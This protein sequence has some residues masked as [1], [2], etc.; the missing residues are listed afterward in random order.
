MR[1]KGFTLIE[2]LVVIAIIGILAAILLPA[3]ARAREAARRASC[4]NNLKQLGLS[5]KMYASE[6]RGEKFPR[7]H[8]DQPFGEPANAV[9]C[10]LA[11]F[12]TDPNAPFAAPAFTPATRAMYPEYMP[13]SNVLI[14]PSD[15]DDGGDNPL[16]IVADDGSDTCQYVGLI[17]GGDQ[18]YNYLGYM[19]DQ[20]DE[21]AMKIEVAPGVEAPAQLV[22]VSA[23]SGAVLF[24]QDPADDVPFDEDIDL[25][26]Y[27]LGGLEAGNGQS[28]TIYRLREGIERF[29][30]TD[31]NKAGVNAQGQSSV[32]IMWDV[33]AANVSGGIGYNHVPGGCN[34]LYMDGHIEFVKYGDKFPATPSNAKL[35]SLFEF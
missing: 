20:V 25:N 14:C 16:F 3:L 8:G 33:I 7:I 6:T 24:N 2:L 12:V 21:D 28:D 34:V 22:G 1:S 35:N 11:S 29:M 30:I 19:L 15:P 32:P 4:A 26:N 5:L 9:G 31:I 27:S 17:T 18:S 23:L 13:D 10:D